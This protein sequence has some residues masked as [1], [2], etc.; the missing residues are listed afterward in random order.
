[1]VSPGVRDAAA[2]QDL[3]FYLRHVTEPGARD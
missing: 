1:M 3:L 2:L